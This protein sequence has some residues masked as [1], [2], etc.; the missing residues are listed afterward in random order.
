MCDTVIHEVLKDGVTSCVIIERELEGS[1]NN[2]I[3]SFCEQ[4]FVFCLKSIYCLTLKYP[5]KLVHP[6]KYH[7]LFIRISIG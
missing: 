2:A 4:F 7:G 3:S 5:G 6:W 1:K